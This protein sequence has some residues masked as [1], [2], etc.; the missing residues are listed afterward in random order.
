VEEKNFKKLYKEFREVL[1]EGDEQKAK[2]FLISHLKEFP[3]E[4]QD[5]I[6]LAFFIEEIGKTIEDGKLLS[7][8]QTK[9]LEE[10]ERIE[11]IEQELKDKLKLIEIQEKISS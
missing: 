5:K 6:I 4:V 9:T 11:L 3:K 8:F 7:D 10:I 2:D 1:Q